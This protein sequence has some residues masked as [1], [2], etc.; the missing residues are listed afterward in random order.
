MSGRSSVVVLKRRLRCS[1]ANKQRT[2]CFA[3]V[4]LVMCSLVVGAL[5]LPAEQTSWKQP[6]AEQMHSKKTA[7]A[8]N[9]LDQMQAM[10]LL[11]DAWRRTERTKTCSVPPSLLRFKRQL[12]SHRF[13][14]LQQITCWHSAHALRGGR[15]EDDDE[16]KEEK[17]QKKSDMVHDH[18]FVSGLPPYANEEWVS[19]L[20]GRN[21]V[22]VDEDTGE[23]QVGCLLDFYD[24]QVENEVCQTKAEKQVG[25]LL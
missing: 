8:P 1:Q 25:C 15:D 9:N 16:D 11:L 24:T 22:K 12:G 23:K 19:V 20:L 21:T 10:G 14:H 5:T 3:L 13:S 2:S 6:C 4:S 17:E 18:V 7:A